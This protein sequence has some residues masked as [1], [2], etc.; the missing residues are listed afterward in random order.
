MLAQANGAAISMY[1]YRT[2]PHTPPPSFHASP[3]FESMSDTDIPHL[4]G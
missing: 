2:V 3:A 4:Q 1:R